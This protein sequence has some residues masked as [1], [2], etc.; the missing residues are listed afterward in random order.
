MCAQP[1]TCRSRVSP[2]AGSV[3]YQRAT[4]GLKNLRASERDCHVTEHETVTAPDLGIHR[5]FMGE[6]DQIAW[7]QFPHHRRSNPKLLRRRAWGGKSKQAKIRLRQ[8]WTVDTKRRPPAKHVREADP[9]PEERQRP[10][11]AIRVWLQELAGK[12]QVLS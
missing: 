9:S 7:L 5:S 8:S 10:P 11:D 2:D 1:I 3:H 6:E 12:E 4:P